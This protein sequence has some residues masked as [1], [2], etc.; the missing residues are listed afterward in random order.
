MMSRAFAICLSLSAST[1][2]SQPA[3]GEVSQVHFVQPRASELA[4]WED[5]YKKHV[6]WHRSKTDP[7]AW[8][9]WEITT[10]ERTGQFA[11]GTFLHEWKDMERGALGAEDRADVLKNQQKYTESHTS[12]IWRYRP[13]ISTP[14]KDSGP[15][16]YA[17]VYYRHVKQGM[18]GTYMGAV[19][20]IN[21]AIANAE[22]GVGYYRN[23][24]LNSGA[25]P[26]MVRFV[27]RPTWEDFT[28]PT[29]SFPKLLEDAYGKEEA[30]AILDALGRSVE[31]GW[32][33]IWTYR[34]DLSYLPSP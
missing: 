11:I 2:T 25:E 31:S 16:A 32:S 4:Q 15:P 5:A 21:D 27:A 30:A 28:P 1:A 13:G 3:Q 19:R 18:L 22:W 20:K 29:P 12:E 26:T 34:P 9:V 14:P 6:E 10:G 33:E 7:W 8:L 17:I 23:V 24:L